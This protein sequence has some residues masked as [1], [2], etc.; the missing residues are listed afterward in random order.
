MV[1]NNR[2]YAILNIA[3]QRVGAEGAGKTA[4]SQLDLAGP[5]LD[6]VQLAQGMGV[7]AE[8]VETCEA[9]YAALQKAFNEP[10]PH[11]IKAVV[12]S[13]FTGVKLK[14]MPHLLKTFDYMPNP[15]AKAIKKIP[16]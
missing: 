10:G 5:D 9:F 16:P 6:F 12:P 8:R 11:L 2:S 4:K 7:P 1:F 13:A 3:L 14:A 15:M